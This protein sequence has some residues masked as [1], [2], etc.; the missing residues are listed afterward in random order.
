MMCFWKDLNSFCFIFDKLLL[1]VDWWLL[2]IWQWKQVYQLKIALLYFSW[3]ICK[4]LKM[5]FKIYW[6]LIVQWITLCVCLST[7]LCSWWRNFTMSRKA[8]SNT[9]DLSE[10]QLATGVKMVDA[11]F[12]YVFE[13]VTLINFKICVELRFFSLSYHV[14][15]HI[16]IFVWFIMFLIGPYCFVL[17]FVGHRVK[18]SHWHSSRMSA[19][20]L[21]LKWLLF[22]ALLSVVLLKIN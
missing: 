2:L 19:C 21:I 8:L 15:N 10:S 11:S 17:H 12:L 13:L 20:Y 6:I 4:E 3:I 22:S 9:C 14:E 5:R 7:Y 1:D 16:L 18:L